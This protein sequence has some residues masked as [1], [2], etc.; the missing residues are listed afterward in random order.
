MLQAIAPHRVGLGA[1]GPTGRSTFVFALDPTDEPTHVV[2]CC[3]AEMDFTPKGWTTL[4]LIYCDG[5][6]ASYTAISLNAEGK[7]QRN[8]TEED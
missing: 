7:F 2:P 8:L 1:N 6:T 5:T 4:K 3:R